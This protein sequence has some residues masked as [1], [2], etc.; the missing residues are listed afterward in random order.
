MKEETWLQLRSLVGGTAVSSSSRFGGIF[1]CL[2]SEWSGLSGKLSGGTG[3]FVFLFEGLGFCRL[4]NAQPHMGLLQSQLSRGWCKEVNR[5]PG[6][7]IPSQIQEAHSSASR[8]NGWK[9]LPRNPRTSNWWEISELWNVWENTI[10][11]S[12]IFPMYIFRAKGTWF[13]PI[14]KENSIA[15]WGFTF[16]LFMLRKI[17]FLDQWFS[18]YDWDPLVSRSWNQF[19]RSRPTFK[20][21]NRI[22]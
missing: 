12:W 5:A 7:G 15:L 3:V 18:N 9:P 16:Q 21:W 4:G 8:L 14:N 22:K 20:K 19:S 11:L 2:Y 13:S 6:Y 1:H 17:P 10:C